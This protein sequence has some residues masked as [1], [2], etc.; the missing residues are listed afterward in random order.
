MDAAGGVWLGCDSG[1]LIRFFGETVQ[2]FGSEKGF[3]G[4]KS[5]ALAEDAS[6]NLWVGTG[7]GELYRGRG[8]QFV[9]D[10]ASNRLHGNGVR[11]LQADADGWLWVGTDGEGLFA[12]HAGQVARIGPEQGLPDSVISQLLEDDFGFVWFGSRR[13]IFKI[14]R[15]ELIDCALGKIPTVTAVLYGRDDGISGLSAV[16]GHQP[17]SWKSRSGQLW[18]T[19]GKGFVSTDPAPDRFERASS[20]VYLEDCSVDGRSL[21]SLGGRV[22]SSARRF[23]FHFYRSDVRSP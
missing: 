18:F 21:E 22:V 19:T 23:E 4:T 8:G 5:E 7:A 14:R 10:S 1:P 11:A 15:D 17:A 12:L 3:T 13:G 6:G 20:R 9:R 16:G 2:K